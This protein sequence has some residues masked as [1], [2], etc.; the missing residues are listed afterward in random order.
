MCSCTPKTS[1]MT[2]T[3]G[4]LMPRNGSARYAG[5]SPSLTGT[6]TSPASRP[7]ASVLIV[8]LDT[9]CTASA[10]PAP[11]ELTI[12]PRRPSLRSGYKLAKCEPP[13]ASIPARSILRFVDDL[14]ADQGVANAAGEL[15]AE[16]GRVLAL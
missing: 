5:I 1:S 9:G 11:S 14:P 12:K 16:E 10:K 8:W 6:F 3:V 15:Q 13:S 2:M 4:K 7:K